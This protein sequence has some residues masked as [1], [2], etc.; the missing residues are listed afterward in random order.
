MVMVQPHEN[1]PRVYIFGY[2]LHHG[3]SGIIGSIICL[4]YRRYKLAAIFL[5]MLIHDRKDFPFTDNCNH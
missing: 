2:R 5:A 4:K 3:T 1:G